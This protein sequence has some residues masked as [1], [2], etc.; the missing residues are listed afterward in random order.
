MSNHK[1]E[2]SPERIEGCERLVSSEV[3]DIYLGAKMGWTKLAMAAAHGC[4]DVTICYWEAQWTVAYNW[5][6]TTN[7]TSSLIKLDFE[8]SNNHLAALLLRKRR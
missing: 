3:E 7:V 1:L 4:R 5:L 2:I 8:V 6:H